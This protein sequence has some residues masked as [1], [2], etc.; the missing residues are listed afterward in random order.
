MGENDFVFLFWFFFFFKQ[1]YL[2]CNSHSIQFHSFKECNQWYLAYWELWSNG[3]N[4]WV[5]SSPPKNPVSTSS[6][7]PFLPSPS[8]PARGNPPLVC[9]SEFCLFWTFQKMESHSTCSFGTDFLH[10][11][12]RF[13][14]RPCCRT[15]SVHHSFLLWNN[16]LL[17]AYPTRITFFSRWILHLSPTPCCCE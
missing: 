17:C 15:W 7:S 16:T 9:D 11:A 8:P 10:W 5:S 13:Q 1:V 4:V 6:H 3:H 14:G 2:R 12:S